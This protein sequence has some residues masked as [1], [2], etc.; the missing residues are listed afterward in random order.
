MCRKETTNKVSKQKPEELGR[1]DV[2]FSLDGSAGCFALNSF[3][4]REKQLLRGALL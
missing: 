3:F 2:E 4:Y 1:L